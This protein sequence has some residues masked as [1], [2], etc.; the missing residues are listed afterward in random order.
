[1]SMLLC[2]DTVLWSIIGDAGLFVTDL[3]V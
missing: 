2:S 3:S 1:M